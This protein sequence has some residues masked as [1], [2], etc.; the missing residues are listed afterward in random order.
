[1]RK[2]GQ[3]SRRPQ[4]CWPL[5]STTGIANFFLTAMAGRRHPWT[6]CPGP[7]LEQFSMCSPKESHRADQ[8]GAGRTDQ[9]RFEIYEM[10][11]ATSR[12]GGGEEPVSPCCIFR[13]LSR[14]PKKK[15]KKKGVSRLR[16][17]L[18]DIQIWRSSTPVDVSS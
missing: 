7:P 6:L 16:A 14:L 13:F 11:I 9:V 5:Y 1:M 17:A 12:S 2:P 18:T 8:P 10:H 4:S 15:K 3:T